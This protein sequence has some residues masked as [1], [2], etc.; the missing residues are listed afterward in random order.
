MI[1]PALC[2]PSHYVSCMSNFNP[3]II[4]LQYNHA[5]TIN[6]MTLNY[7]FTYKVNFEVIVN[8]NRLY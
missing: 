4:E 8:V 6:S 7:T 2:Y 5:L 1:L 3:F